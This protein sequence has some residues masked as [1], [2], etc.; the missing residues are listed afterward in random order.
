MALQSH[1]SVLFMMKKKAAETDEKTRLEKEK[2]RLEK[3]I[4]QLSARLEQVEESL[5]NL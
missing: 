2:K 1:D 4:S 5:A 3:T